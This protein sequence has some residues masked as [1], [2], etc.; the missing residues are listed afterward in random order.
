[1][2]FQFTSF[3]EFMAMDGHGIYV[4]A[5]YAITFAALAA[6]ALFPQLARRRLQRE[7][8]HQQRIAKRRRKV[9]E[10]RQVV[11]ETA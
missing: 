5:S 11:E 1:M 2:Q 4:W 10:E 6:M 9:K 3:A 7:L 8:Q